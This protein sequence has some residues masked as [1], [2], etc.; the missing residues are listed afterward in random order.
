MT[1]GLYCIRDVKSVYMQPLTD[2]NDQ[3]AI[4][5]FTNAVNQPG[6]LFSQNPTDY[7]FY[8]VGTWD[9]ESGLIKSFK[10]PKFICD[11]G[12]VMKEVN[13]D[14]VSDAV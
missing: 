4:R 10:E 5:N 14:E 3:T 6:S 13:F 7:A 9:C 12:Q 2:H 8:K 11:A 1:Y